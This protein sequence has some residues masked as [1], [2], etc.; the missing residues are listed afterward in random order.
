[1]NNQNTAIL[2]P[3]GVAELVVIPG[4]QLH[5]RWRQLDAGLGVHNGGPEIRSEVLSWKFEDRYAG[6]DLTFSEKVPSVTQEIRGDNHVGGVPQ[7]ALK[8][9]SLTGSLQHLRSV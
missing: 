6:S 5:E 7:D 1:M 2:L 4:D 8:G 3:V 9:P